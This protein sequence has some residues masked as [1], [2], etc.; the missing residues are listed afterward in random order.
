MTKVR[1]PDYDSASAGPVSLLSPT[2]SASSSLF[3][4]DWAIRWISD[5]RSTFAER[6]VAFATGVDKRKGVPKSWEAHLG[7]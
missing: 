3:D 2:T 7:E 6:L 4:A 5:Q 1:T